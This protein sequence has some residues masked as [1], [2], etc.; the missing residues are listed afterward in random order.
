MGEAVKK[1]AI[2]ERKDLRLKSEGDTV[3]AIHSFLKDRATMQTQIV[4]F[5][6]VLM[7]VLGAGVVACSSDDSA[8]TGAGGSGGSAGAGTAGKGGTAG[9][10]AGSAG[11]GGSSGASGA[12][13][14]GNGGGG[15]TAGSKGDAAPDGD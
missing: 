8:A 7:L 11:K 13:G 10:N 5:G 15:G 2:S 6:S 14:A 4:R 9:T 3:R 12:S 1:S